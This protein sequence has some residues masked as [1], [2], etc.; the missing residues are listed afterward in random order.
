[1]DEEVVEDAV[2]EVELV[3]DEAK[4]S[5]ILNIWSVETPRYLA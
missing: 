4:N 3:D 5:L 2:A 1:L